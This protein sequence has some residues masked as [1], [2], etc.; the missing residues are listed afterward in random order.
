MTIRT[1]SHRPRRVTAHPLA[2]QSFYNVNKILFIYYFKLSYSFFHVNTDAG[3]RAVVT[4]SISICCSHFTETRGSYVM[5]LPP[6]LC[7]LLL[8]RSRPL[9][10]A[11]M[12]YVTP[13]RRLLATYKFWNSPY[14]TLGNC[15][16]QNVVCQ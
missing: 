2:E 9:H 16:S 12:R 11:S 13:T 14:Q 8:T 6:K 7:P 1:T 10:L 3:Y 4:F 15:Y 5:T